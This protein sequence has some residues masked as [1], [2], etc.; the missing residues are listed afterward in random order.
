MCS[1]GF[2]TL[3]FKCGVKY[4]ETK[5]SDIPYDTDDNVYYTDIMIYHCP[6]CGNIERIEEY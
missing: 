1:S 6:K 5:K 4:V 2:E 3:N